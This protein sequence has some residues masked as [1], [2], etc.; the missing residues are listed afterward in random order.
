MSTQEL[1]AEQFARLFAHYQKALMPS[2]EGAPTT[3]EAESWESAP[4]SERER[5][6]A[7]GRL[8]LMDLEA[9]DGSN[10]RRWYARPGQAEWGC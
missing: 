9:G 1:F 3:L 7:A 2:S 8:A 6:L 5:M 4:D 10:S